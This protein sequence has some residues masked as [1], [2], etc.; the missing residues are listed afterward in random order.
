MG[1]F[2]AMDATLCKSIPRSR[3]RATLSSRD[4]RGSRYDMRENIRLATEAWCRLGHMVRDIHESIFGTS[5][6]FEALSVGRLDTCMHVF[7]CRQTDC[8]AQPK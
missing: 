2:P 6:A 1:D 4:S 5:R 8:V 7:G 3:D